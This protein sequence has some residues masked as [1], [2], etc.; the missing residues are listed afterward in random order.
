MS[1]P[2]S[3]TAKSA[4]RARHPKISKRSLMQAYSEWLHM[5][6]RMLC[7]ELY[8]D[9][10]DAERFV[11]CNTGVGEFHLPTGRDSWRVPKPSTRARAILEAAGVDL[12]QIK[13]WKR[14]SS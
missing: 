7:M 8:P 10:P 5:E 9:D 3:T 4:R 1:K 13:E 14:A 12:S 6:R 2:S 11:P